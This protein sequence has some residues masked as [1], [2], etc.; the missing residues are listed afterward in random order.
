MHGPPECLG[1]MILLCAAHL[2]PNPKLSLGFAN[3]MIDD[4]H[5]IPERDLVESCAMEHSLDFKKINSCI[6]EEGKAQEMLRE[7]VEKSAKAN[8]TTSC[9]VRLNGKVRCVRDGGKWKDCEGGSDVKSLVKDVKK[10]F[11]E[12]NG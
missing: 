7:S 10:A 11:D 12:M 3:C 8:V 6:S 9:T 2:Y 5:D 4:Y 1:N